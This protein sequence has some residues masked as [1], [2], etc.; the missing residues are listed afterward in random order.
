MQ[1]YDE[2]QNDIVLHQAIFFT[3]RIH[4][5]GYEYRYDKGIYC[6]NAGHDNGYKGLRQDES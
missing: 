1:S 3:L 2:G 5:S 4:V 6:N